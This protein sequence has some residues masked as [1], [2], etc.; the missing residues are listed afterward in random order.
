MTDTPTGPPTPDLGTALADAFEQERRASP[1]PGAE[2][3]AVS[4]KAPI[5]RGP[6]SPGAESDREAGDLGS[7]RDELVAQR[8]VL[9]AIEQRLGSP[10]VLLVEDPSVGALT[11]RL[12]GAEDELR[13]LADGAEALQ[14][15]LAEVRDTVDAL[16]SSGRGRDEA[17]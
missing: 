16:R 8:E 3:T 15:L 1:E 11:Q 17:S 4:S 12:R 10:D 5:S 2:G 7:L 6:T 13:R 14:S 9:A